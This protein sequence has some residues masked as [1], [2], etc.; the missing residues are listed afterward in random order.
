MSE[1]IR[2]LSGK[3]ARTTPAKNRRVLS[4]YPQ[5]VLYV[6][7]SRFATAYQI[8]RRFPQQLASER[9]A[10]RRLAH[11]VELGHLAIASVRSTAPYFPNVYLATGKGVRWIQQLAAERGLTFTVSPAEERKERGRALDSVLHELL[12]TELEL[13]VHQSVGNRADLSLPMT[14]RR[15]FRRTRRLTYAHQGGTQHLIP[16]AGLRSPLGRRPHVLDSLPE[17][18][19]HAGDHRRIAM[20]H[21]FRN[22]N[23]IDS[24]LQGISRKGMTE[25]VGAKIG[26]QLVLQP[27][28]QATKPATR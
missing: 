13:A 5:V 16:D 8:A 12:L 25:A 20:S 27:S 7:R 18:L 17:V 14:E 2:P 23:W 15:Y 3:R 11:L 19:V 21:E 10:H 24:P 26:R 1:L 9:T 6:F 28:P 22:G 4:Y